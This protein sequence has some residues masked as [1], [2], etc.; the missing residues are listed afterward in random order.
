MIGND[1]VDLE[2]A[3]RESNWRRP[4]FLEKVFT[5]EEQVLINQSAEKDLIVWVLWSM[6]E[7]AYKI[8]SRLEKKRFFA[9]EKLKCSARNISIRESYGCVKFANYTITTKSFINREHIHTIAQNK[10]EEFLEFRSFFFPDKQ[11]GQ[12]RIHTY[13]HIITHYAKLRGLSELQLS[14]QK[15]HFGVP[16][17]YHKNKLTSAMISMSHHGNYGG[18]CM[19]HPTYSSI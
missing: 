19:I 15:D 14:I 16:Y 5:S 3:R 10:W 2:S 6:K 17:V 11:F 4:R 9:P 8:I 1:I 12:Q 7:S 18:Y 13:R